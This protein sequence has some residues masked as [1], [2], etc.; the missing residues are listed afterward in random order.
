MRWRKNIEWL[1]GASAST[2]PVSAAVLAGFLTIS[3]MPPVGVKGQEMSVSAELKLNETRL[4]FQQSTD[5][6]A[7]LKN[8]GPS[9]ISKVNPD[10]MG[11]GATLVLTDVAT[12]D[13]R[14]FAT[15]VQP[16]VQSVDVNLDKGESLK[17]EF[18]LSDRVTI[19]AP[20]I[21]ELKARYQWGL[22]STV[23]SPAVRIEVLESRPRST[24]PVVLQKPP[25]QLYLVAWLNV[26]DVAKGSFQVWLSHVT[27]YGRPKVRQCFH[28]ADVDKVVQPALAAPPNGQSG[29][30]WVAWLNGDRLVYALNRG[31]EVTAESTFKLDDDTYR[32]I[33]PLLLNPTARGESIQGFDALLYGSVPETSK[34]FLGVAHL[35]PSGKGELSQPIEVPATAP[36]WASTAHLANGDRYTFMAINGL[37]SASLE[38]ARWSATKSPAKIGTVASWPARCLACDFALGESDA[39]LGAMVGEVGTDAS[40]DYTLYTWRFGAPDQF[41]DAGK[42]RI[43]VPEGVG[44][45][46]AIVRVNADGVPFALLRTTGKRAAWYFC[47]PKGTLMALPSD[48]ADFRMPGDILF[49]DGG[50]PVIMFGDPPRG[51][52]LVKPG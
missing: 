23:E 22:G 44:V 45:D 47:G 11:A 38:M 52:Q 51:F 30:Q 25:T 7:E 46:Q 39:V 1:D 12:G 5:C 32:L 8:A 17:D 10:N 29:V 43:A 40:R 37:N 6:V 50:D 2:R 35:T 42:V 31:S 36:V 4:L 33:P 16:G 18:F 24:F 41:Q 26:I 49:R 21:Y 48:A 15:P 27:G 3:M 9:P 13:V 19:P 14:T 34:H 20:G 28:V